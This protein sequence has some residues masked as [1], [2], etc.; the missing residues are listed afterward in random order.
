MNT[1]IR[2]QV[3]HLG[4]DITVKTVSSAAYERFEQQCRLK[5]V[6][7]L[8]LS[9][10]GAGRFRLPLA[11]AERLAPQAGA[12]TLRHIPASVLALA[13]L[14]EIDTQIARHE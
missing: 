5:E 14:Y 13:E 9:R 8:D 4:G 7:T 6:H 12:I 2:E 1:E 11:A 3:L 10:R